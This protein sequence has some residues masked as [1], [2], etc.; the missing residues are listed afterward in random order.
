MYV[1]QPVT[2]EVAK[3]NSVPQ[4]KEGKGLIAEE[5]KGRWAEVG[6]APPLGMSRIRARRQ[7]GTYS[8]FMMAPNTTFSQLP[9]QPF[10]WPRVYPAG[11][12]VS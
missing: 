3:K 5:W 12:C 4:E 10:I 8:T 1:K 11:W 9:P 2:N 7:R 6:A